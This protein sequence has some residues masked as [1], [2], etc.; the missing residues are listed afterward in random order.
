MKI[1]R[2]KAKNVHGYLNFDIKFNDRLSFLTGIN[3]TGKTTALNSIVALLLPDLQFLCNVHY[4]YIQVSIKLE[5]RKITIN[6][7]SNE[8]GATLSIAGSKKSVELTSYLRD[9]DVP[10]YRQEDYEAEYYREQISDLR[11]NEVIRE[12]IDL[13]S[14]M[15]LGLDRRML[16]GSVRRQKRIPPSRIA[17]G[18][19]KKTVFSGSM[20]NRLAEAVE[21]AEHSHAQQSLKQNALDAEFQRQLLLELINIAP[22]STQGELLAPTQTETQKIGEWLDTFATLPNILKLPEDDVNLAIRPM[23]TFL[24]ELK[25]GIQKIPHDVSP[26]EVFREDSNR[27]TILNWVM[28]Q[29]YIE[30]IQRVV[31]IIEKYDESRN[32]IEELNNRYLHGINRFF[33]DGGK[34]VNFNTRGR[35]SFSSMQSQGDLG[36]NSLS[37]GEIQLFVILTHLYFNPDAAEANLFIIDEPELSLHV[38][39]QEEFVSALL[40]ATTD[41]Q[42]ILATHAPSI[43]LHRVDQCIEIEHV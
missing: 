4:E 43:I 37:S 2:F 27:D 13:P 21:L 3:G 34:E 7:K 25:R 30:K 26:D 41:V 35:I 10:T 42:L 20:E 5:D 15:Y 36:F 23:S 22:I 31:S 32:K 17:R 16:H 24:L 40:E 11:N 39:W 8:G 19:Q 1:L 6:S 12:I 38:N 18:Y 9:P 33:T 14:P 28:N 29:P